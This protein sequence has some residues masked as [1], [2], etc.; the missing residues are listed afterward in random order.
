MSNV[1][2]SVASEFNDKGFKQADKG[3]AA[4]TKS[5]AKFAG[6]LALAH[7]AQKAMLSY[8]A[9]E[10]ATKVLAQNLKNLG[11]AYAV[12]SAEAFIKTLQT[13]TGILDDEL[14]PAYAQLAR[15]TGSTLETQRLMN[16][17][18]NVAAGSG[19]DYNSVIDA[20]SK[21]YV[22]NYKGLKSLNIG[23]TDAELKSK[24]FADIVDLLNQQFQG[25][26]KA[27]L[28]SYAGQMALLQVASA[29]ASEA[30]GKSLLNAITTISGQGG[31]PA[32]IN[33]IKSSVQWLDDLVTGTARL[34]ATMGLLASSQTIAQKWNAWRQLQN[35]WNAEDLQVQKERSGIANNYTSYFQKQAAI[36]L[37][38]AKY[39]TLT[40]KADAARLATL[41]KTTLEKKAQAALDKANLAIGAANNVFDLERIGVAAAMQNATLTENEKKRLEIKQAIFAL[42]DAIDSKDTARITKQTDI[43]NGLLGQFNT[44]QKQD[45]LLGQIRTTLSDLGVNKDL[46]N[47]LNLQEALALLKEMNLVLNGTKQGSTSNNIYSPTL[48]ADIYKATAA[49]TFASV[50]AKP[51]TQPMTLAAAGIPATADISNLTFADVGASPF[52][53]PMSISGQN[54]TVIVQITDNAQKL[55]DAVTFATQNNSANGTPVALSR[56]ATNL[57]W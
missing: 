1:L 15:V 39:A 34:I 19:Q 49:T 43:L 40:N 33:S 37:A 13:Q 36:N 30:I 46:I 53:T 57:A 29:D 7:K 54:P 31:F 23:L 22:G 38:S 47:I 8:I 35:K 50:G 41:K 11:L 55:V 48:S 14:R 32:L 51:F 3:M 25:S 26:G 56:N 2:I 45:A 24:S 18:F 17:A 10:K 5:A 9:D 20:L 6:S 12:P 42:E 21:A 16:T 4:L 27:S 52:K 28:E 44:M